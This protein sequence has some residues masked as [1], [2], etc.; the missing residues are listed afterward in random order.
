MR[1][2]AQAA[3]EY[4]QRA[5]QPMEGWP[6]RIQ[7]IPGVGRPVSAAARMGL[8]G[9]MQPAYGAERLI[10]G[11][12][13][14]GMRK[15]PFEQLPMKQ[16]HEVSRIVYSWIG[17]QEKMQNMSNRLQAGENL[18]E[19]LETEKVNWREMV[20]QIFLDPL[21]LI[22]GWLSKSQQ[23]KALKAARVVKPAMTA[24]QLGLT[25]PSRFETFA[26]GLLAFWRP[27]PKTKMMNLGNR[28]GRV[29]HGLLEGID[30]VDEVQAVLNT[31]K[32]NPQAIPGALSMT[33]DAQRLTQ[34]LNMADVDFGKGIW[35]GLTEAGEIGERALPTIKSLLA[36]EEV[37]PE[38]FKYGLISNLQDVARD[39][40]QRVFKVPPSTAAERLAN[41][42]KGG[43]SL[44]LLGFSPGYVV[45]NVL[46]NEALALIA[47]IHAWST[48][49]AQRRYFSKVMGIADPEVLEKMLVT[50]GI[51]RGI[52]AA[53]PT[54]G[55]AARTP[56]I[57]AAGK[58]EE[59][60][61]MAIVHKV[62]SDLNRDNWPT[63]LREMLDSD[64]WGEVAAILDRAQPGRSE[65]V[66][67]A[68]GQASSVE[69]LKTLAVKAAG[70]EPAV[71]QFI[72][73][74]DRLHPS[75]V[76][77]LQQ[78]VDEG[79]DLGVV[80]RE[81]AAHIAAGVDDV[82]QE[83]RIDYLDDIAHRAKQTTDDGFEGLLEQFQARRE[84]AQMDAIEQALQSMPREVD[85]VTHTEA[86]TRLV[87]EIKTTANQVR[88]NWKKTYFGPVKQLR[89][90]TREGTV[91]GRL[92]PNIAWPA[93]FTE[94]ETRA[95][96]AHQFEISAWDTL[97]GRFRTGPGRGGR[98]HLPDITEG[99]FAETSK[100]AQAVERIRAGLSRWTMGG[101]SALPEED[102]GRLL[103]FIDNI[104]APGMRDMHDATLKLALKA[105]E[106]TLLNYANRLNFDWWTNWIFPYEFWYTHTAKNLV[107]HMID[108]P[109]MLASYYR[110]KMALEA[111]TNEPGYPTRMKGKIKMR[112]PFLPD[113]MG[114]ELF[115]DPLRTFVP[116]ETFI[117][118]YLPEEEG[119]TPLGK[120]MR[121]LGSIMSPA[122]WLTLPLAASGALGPKEQWV[123]GAQIP[124][125][126]YL[127]GITGLM[128]QTKDITPVRAM[129]G[130]P[131]GETW[132]PY[133]VDR[134][135]ANMAGTG[136]IDSFEARLAM[137]LR[138]G[139][140][141]EEA[142]R[143]AGQE[144][145]ITLTGQMAGI[146]GL[147]IYPAGER[148]Q[149]ALKE[150]QRAMLDAIR[151]GLGT[152]QYEQVK[153]LR[154]QDPELDE[155]VAKVYS[156]FYEKNPQ[157][158]A[159]SALWKDD[160]ELAIDIIW[161][162][163]WKAGGGKEARKLL[164]EDFSPRF[165][166]Y[167]VS[168]DT[169]D[170]A[171]FTDDELRIMARRLAGKVTE[172]PEPEGKVA[173]G[174]PAAGQPGVRLPMP[175]A[176]RA[177]A[178]PRGGWRWQ[179]RRVGRR[180][181]GAGDWESFS[182][183]IEDKE[184][185]SLISGYLMQPK[186]QRAAFARRYK[187][188]LVW[189]KGKGE[190]EIERLEGLYLRWLGAQRRETSQAYGAR[191]PN[192]RWYRR[193]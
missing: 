78:V 134:M 175:P 137:L 74:I 24:E 23:G 128:G 36:G 174:A 76:D 101:W 170:Y 82:A 35:Q 65:A 77:R 16:Q 4:W 54:A 120:T 114:G 84:A 38:L 113:W 132:D 147:S 8:T 177:Y 21:I 161:D 136:E 17:N 59:V 53:G 37:A 107:K 148:I 181:R 96:S 75:V 55:L 118:P 5:Q 87:A 79:G 176:R 18:D 129:M 115:I 117:D 142:Q 119:T 112:L 127:K 153:A 13:Q 9:L 22:G 192:L 94:R 146:S 25:A 1:Q 126:R 27:T 69:D 106:E 32:L 12:A 91:A 50:L 31:L 58:A 51:K 149:R 26:R 7:N 61:G 187:K 100:V 163:Y 125:L 123:S 193:W 116:I 111:A 29:V 152:M 179:P 42:L 44:T 95:A 156:E 155:A 190:E 39:V 68:L 34:V 20:G 92:D 28:S 62:Q 70:G 63:F 48:P 151:P 99:S 145:G 182:E 93:Y 159:R 185:V 81:G 121:G 67:R 2:P 133:R 71:G 14:W 11:A 43:M 108:R 89:V 73:E 97:L 124:A 180:A 160:R 105:R 130:L 172:L 80:V 178:A 86:A 191:A 46:S 164:G 72:D 162:A 45:R 19:V 10:G 138:E 6:A 47:G 64:E 66:R 167:F 183:G 141:Y 3:G 186:A 56:G 144:R 139:P 122:P 140:I 49:A 169:R 103:G 85:E 109:A 143:K 90:Q 102:A 33:E 184:L 166:E 157:Y 57:V 171:Q 52:G 41:K 131:Q 189:L 188:L 30:N 88:S 60:K 83:L 110:M 165:I 168:R 104:V 98:P 15:D 150:D 40:G 154:A 173:L 158:E 135:L